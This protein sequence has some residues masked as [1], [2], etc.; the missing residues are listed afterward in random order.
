MDWCI[1][2]PGVGVSSI[3]LRPHTVFGPARDQGMT[4]VPTTAMVAAAA[5]VACYIPFGGQVQLQYAPDVGEAFVRAAE[6]QREGASVH[7]LDGAVVA[8]RDLVGV[9]EAAAPGAQ[10]LITT[11]EDALPF[12]G[13]VDASSFHTPC[14][15]FE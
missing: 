10:G 8:V 13:S 3:G 7:N 9:I 2:A 12:P 15:E 4:S 11:A 1:N 6:L 14:E 5:G